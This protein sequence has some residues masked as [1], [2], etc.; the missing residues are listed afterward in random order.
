MFRKD[1]R[2]SLF[3]QGA[4][5]YLGWSGNVVSNGVLWAAGAVCG[6][7]GSLR[8]WEEVMEET[9]ARGAVLISMLRGLGVQCFLGG[10]P[11]SVWQVRTVDLASWVMGGYR[12]GVAPE[13]A[14]TH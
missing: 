7:A 11:E 9:R 8:G 5:E 6:G 12:L 10:E 1:C 3:Q 2:K 4:A 13:E 14:R